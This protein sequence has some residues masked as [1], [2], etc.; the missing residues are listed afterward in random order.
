MPRSTTPTTSSSAGRRSRA[1]SS[2]ARASAAS[3]GAAAHAKR[4]AGRKA[5]P[6]G[7]ANGVRA[8]ANGGANGKANGKASG[9]H[10]LLT[11]GNSSLRQL[12]R[13]GKVSGEV[14]GP[15]LL[16]VLPPHILASQEKLEDVTSLFNRHGIS[17]RDW[18]PPVVLRKP[19]TRRPAS[20]GDYD[21]YRSND[22]VRVYLREMGAVSL[23][24]R[25]GEVEIAKRIEAGEEDELRVI[26][27]SPI[28]WLH[29]L[30]LGDLIRK[31]AQPQRPGGPRYT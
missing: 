21:G 10:S 28:V 8:K 1:V 17:V 24:T 20:G 19:E 6:N 15:L 25:E 11:N 26:L 12:L 3:N 2:K 27:K 5:K 22:P 7:K 16:S 9:A 23:L 18:K 13:S 4:A 31:G 29:L 30:E 14:E